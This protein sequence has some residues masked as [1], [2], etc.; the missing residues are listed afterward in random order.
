MSY[1]PIA[2]TIPQY[3]NYPNYWMKAYEEGT[4]TPKV[5]ATDAAA[6][7][8]VA[9]FELNPDGFPR[10][11]G[12]ALVIPFIDGFYDLWLF[13]TAAEADANDT[14]SAFQIADN[15]T[16]TPSYPV[17]VNFAFDPKDYGATS[18]VDSNTEI[19][20]CYDAAA[21]LGKD[22]Y[23]SGTYRSDDSINTKGVKTYGKGTLDFSN[24]TSLSLSDACLYDEGTITSLGAPASA[25]TKSDSVI[26]M[27]APPSLA[28]GDVVFIYSTEMFSY[29]RAA[30]TKGE[31]PIVNNIS[32]NEIRIKGQLADD[33]ASA[34]AIIYKL[35]PTSPSYEDITVI[36]PEFTG[37]YGIRVKNGRH[38][39][40]ECTV[41]SAGRVAVML[42]QCVDSSVENS[43]LN[44]VRDSANTIPSG[45]Y[46]LNIAN[47]E[48][49]RVRSST[50][51]GERH[52]ITTGGFSNDVAT[53][54]SELLAI[55][56][57]HI[58]INGNYVES[59]AL[60]YENTIEDSGA[61]SG[62]VSATVLT[63]S[64]QAWA[65]DTWVGV[66]VRNT[67]TGSY[68]IALSNTATTITFDIMRGIGDLNW[69]ASDAYVIARGAAVQAI[70]LHG[71]AEFVDISNNIIMNGVTI[72]GNHITVTD[73]TLYGA[74]DNGNTL[75]K[76]AEMQGFDH[77]ISGN[78][79][80][81]TI[82]NYPRTADVPFVAIA[83]S[84]DG[85]GAVQSNNATKLGGTLIINDNKFVCDDSTILTSTTPHDII[86]R[87][88]NSWTGGEYGIVF[89]DNVTQFPPS[90]TL[91]T[92]GLKLTATDNGLTNSPDL[93]S[94]LSGKGNKWIN[95]GAIRTAVETIGSQFSVDRITCT[96]DSVQANDNADQAYRFANVKSY[97][98]CSNNTIDSVK[99]APIQVTNSDM[100]TESMANAV[101]SV[102][103]KDN[104]IT[105]SINDT[106]TNSTKT[107]GLFIGVEGLVIE[108]NTNFTDAA[109]ELIDLFYID[110]WDGGEVWRSK[111]LD[112]GGVTSY[113]LE[114]TYAAETIDHF[115]PTYES[116]INAVTGTGYTAT[117]EDKGIL[118]TM[119]N[120]SANTFTVPPETTVKWANGAELYVSQI[121][122]GA[123]TIV[124]GAGV[125]I[126]TEVGLVLNARY[127]DAKLVK[128]GTNTWL[129][130][131]R[132][133]A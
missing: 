128:T 33:Y 88:D 57:R 70:S 112:T 12:G 27:S 66:A 131:G 9:K 100:T 87:M 118:V 49:V 75:I 13:P 54:G 36:A 73:N 98:N 110:T 99:S 115:T 59:D 60:L 133:K 17:L 23:I 34:S 30:Y 48:R 84:F 79:A 89:E 7:T 5:M 97:V 93:M 78:L 56:C 116:A 47:C 94:F 55:V 71:N 117:P 16:T 132:L 106:T 101:E 40:V 38:V 41:K 10:T 123:T 130:T 52:G 8:T 69:N 64:S 28:S 53:P 125:T 63:D 61:H 11:A 22:V 46:G 96:G 108:G 15:I 92:I 21:L 109:S 90:I 121:G 72:G 114:T 120:A 68:G 50:I 44:E 83:F 43:F 24:A 4:T 111:N 86:Y 104:T 65:T 3:E 37:S 81:A 35:N 14:G 76:G 20:A 25:I 32:G 51:S 107:M 91:A 119:N 58:K 102:V 122:A 82:R 85:S 105:N 6:G 18:G 95:V 1:A 2:Y 113:G 67:T 29:A 19:Q 62:T 124:A 45:E 77:K 80:V 26:V 127:A 42:Q 103:V 74:N 31:A 129:A 126:N 39:K